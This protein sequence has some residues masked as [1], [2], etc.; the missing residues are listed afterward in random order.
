VAV[1]GFLWTH[2]PNCQNSSESAHLIPKFTQWLQFYRAF[3]HERL[4]IFSSRS[5]EALNEQL[6]RENRGLA[7]TSVPATQFL[8]ERG[9]TPR[10]AV[11][12]A[13]AGGSR[14]NEPTISIP[15]RTSPSSDESCVSPLEKRREEIERGAG[16]D[17]DLP[18]QCMLPTSLP[19]VLAWVKLL[20]RVQQGDLQPEVVACGS[21]NSDAQGVS[22]FATHASKQQGVKRL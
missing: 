7:S 14:A 12:E 15:A 6:V 4:R 16:G 1:P 13:F 18:Y 9:I 17:H 5:Q 8:H 3:P 22:R 20:A 10:G 19:Q 21:G 11:S 2:P